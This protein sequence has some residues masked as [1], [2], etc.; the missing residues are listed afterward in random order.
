MRVQLLLIIF[1]F[2]KKRLSPQQLLAWQQFLLASSQL[3]GNISEDLEAE[4][5]LPLAW[6][7]I[8]YSLEAQPEKRLR[9]SEL[10]DTVLMSRSGLTRLIDR[11]EKAGYLKRVACKHDRRGI[12]AELTE[13]GSTALKRSWPAYSRAVFKHFADK[14]DAEETDR[15][16]QLLGKLNA[17]Q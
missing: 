7:D 6:Y 11:V 9:L 17:E 4:D 5:A 13:K 15:L 12:H 16:S 2:M 1:L 8:L 10:A 3:L 14:L